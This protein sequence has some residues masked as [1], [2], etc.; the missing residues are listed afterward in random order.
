MKSFFIAKLNLTLSSPTPRQTLENQLL[1]IPHVTIDTYKDSNL[2][3]V[4][5]KGKEF[6]HFHDAQEIDIRLSQKFAR[7]HQLGSPIISKK[8]PNRSKNS[9]WRVMQFTSQ[10]EAEQL[11]ALI[12]TLIE[13]EYQ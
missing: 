11:F 2:V 8:H 3:C 9:R 5:F 6:A 10:E 12:C 7:K 13:E 4:Y 1:T